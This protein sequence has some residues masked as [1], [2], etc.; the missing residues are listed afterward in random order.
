[1]PEEIALNEAAIVL[2]DGDDVAVTRRKIAGDTTLI[3]HDAPNV[4][5][6]TDIPAGHKVALRDIKPGSRCGATGKS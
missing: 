2:R 6:A 4:T 3:T 1:M 5:L